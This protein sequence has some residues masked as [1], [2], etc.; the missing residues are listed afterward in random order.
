[1]GVVPFEKLEFE[2]S[3]QAVKVMDKLREMLHI[4]EKDKKGEHHE[5]TD[6]HTGRLSGSD[7]EGV[8]VHKVDDISRPQQQQPFQGQKHHEKSDLEK[9]GVGPDDEGVRVYEEDDKGSGVSEQQHKAT[10]MHSSTHVKPVLPIRRPLHEEATGESVEK[11]KMVSTAKE[12]VEVPVVPN[13]R[14]LH[15]E[16]TGESIEKVKVVAKKEVNATIEEPVGEKQTIETEVSRRPVHDSAGKAE[17]G[18]K[19]IL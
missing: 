16:N 12:E 10:A 6:V 5:T 18:K 15:E 2:K 19:F 4:K 1:M 11:V 9:G 3:V 8:R 17:K 7:Y 13:R 14:P